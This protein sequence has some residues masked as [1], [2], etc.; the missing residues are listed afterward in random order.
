MNGYD[1]WAAK[2]LLWAYESLL[3]TRW[4]KHSAQCRANPKFPRDRPPGGH[5]A[6]CFAFNSKSICLLFLLSHTESHCGYIVTDPT[7]SCFLENCTFLSANPNALDDMAFSCLFSRCFATWSTS[8]LY[9]TCHIENMFDEKKKDLRVFSNQ[10]RI[11]FL[12]SWSHLT[13]T[14]QPK[15]MGPAVLKTSGHRSQRNVQLQITHTAPVFRAWRHDSWEAGD[16]RPLGNMIQSSNNLLPGWLVS[17]SHQIWGNKKMQ[18]ANNRFF[19]PKKP[20]TLCS[21]FLPNK[22]IDVSRAEPLP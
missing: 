13:E 4:A 20:A 15:P 16:L 3:C 14:P 12:P 5:S 2:T 6:R 11:S 8:K 18:Q 21:S 19:F 1:G 7:L 22:N 9:M 17:P 10:I